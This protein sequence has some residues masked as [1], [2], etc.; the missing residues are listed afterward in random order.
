MKKIFL[1]ILISFS[2]FSQV[3]ELDSTFKFEPVTKRY[4]VFTPLVIQFPNDL[5]LLNFDGN[6]LNNELKE[7]GNF[8]IN[9]KGKIVE[10]FKNKDGL[11][12]DYRQE[13]NL[14][15]PDN[16][17][18]VPNYS[19]YPSFKLVRLFQNGSVDSTFKST[20]SKDYIYKVFLLHN[21]N[22]LV[23]FAAENTNY[24]HIFDKNG[25]FI[26]ILDLTKYGFMPD[27]RLTNL[28]FNDFNE[29]FLLVSDS[30]GSGEIIKTNQDF[31]IDKDFPKIKYKH[32]D[33]PTN[34]LERDKNGFFLLK[35]EDKNKIE[36]YDRNGVK[37]WESKFDD[38]SMYG[39]SVPYVYHQND[40]S[41]DLIYYDRKHIKIKA[42]GAI[43]SVF[44]NNPKQQ[45]IS[46]IHVFADG[47]YWIMQ[48]NSG[49]V[50]KMYADGSIDT[51]FKITLQSE[52]KLLPN[53]IEKLPNKNYLIDLIDYPYN[54][55]SALRYSQNPNCVRIYNGKHQLI[56]DFF[57]SKTIWKTYK[58][59]DSFIVRGD[60]KFYTIDNN[61][62]MSISKDTLLVDDVI[63]WNNN[64]V[65]RKVSENSIVRFKL[66]VGIDKDFSI[67][68]N[69]RIVSFKILNDTQIA[70]QIY[71]NDNFSLYMYYTNGLQDNPFKSIELD[72][73]NSAAPWSQQL[74][75][76]NANG[77]IINQI[78]YIGYG[79]IS[80]RFV[81]LND[82]GSID[83]NYQQNTISGGQYIRYLE[84]GTIYTS[85]ASIIEPKYEQN[86]YNF[87]KILPN[88]KIDSTFQLA[89][90]NEVYGF[91]FFDENTLYATSGKSLYRFIKN[92]LK[93]AEYFNYQTLPTKI[94][95]DY[96]F[97]L[98]IVIK[99]T[100][101]NIKVNVSGN[102]I[103]K[104]SLIAVMPKA[105]FIYV[106][107]TDE[108]NK[109]LAFQ[110]IEV[111]K[112]LPYFIYE[113]RQLTVTSRAFTFKVKASSGL[114][115]K[116]KA[117]GN[118]YAD[119]LIID[120][121]KDQYLSIKLSSNGNEQYES[122]EKSFYW[123]ISSPLANEAEEQTGQ[124]IYY[125]NPVSDKLTIETNNLKIDSFKLIAIDG[126]EIPFSITEEENKYQ[127]TI[128]NLPHG[129]YILL[130]KSKDKQF[131]YR[132]LIE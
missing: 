38:V 73:K 76:D 56:Y 35:T 59:K 2:A 103:L 92:P 52:K 82:D 65:Y 42:D 5:L 19:S 51:N 29:Y 54:Y 23:F 115:V 50:E 15:T 97:P 90:V 91:E 71:N 49:I 12:F 86:V 89:G 24:Y 64:F 104:D 85:S 7:T 120:P 28:V 88:G 126:K 129:L 6:V 13:N 43:D 8:L 58:T 61:S 94:T 110:T 37:I 77:L 118:E 122:I 25:S 124:I 75:L 9:T 31:E 36:K 98:K 46:F 66:G 17:L 114:P 81:K 128:S 108:N 57:D 132:L 40:G 62:K 100:I 4:N 67:Y 11:G 14:I 53:Q 116:I 44:Y 123:T 18:L 60:G 125:P 72:N 16:K 34:K 83:K 21:E 87:L 10:T 130:A 111:T 127:L 112:I 63:D 131:S 113:E 105:G 39:S 20:V 30:N 74:N 119:S 84:D 109:V 107:I 78:L 1:L 22:F 33:S 79:S 106:N 95:W 68:A 99:T 101:K 117:Y 70:V 47:T 96:T 69:R 102:G 32:E 93:K 41:L 55:L 27:A 3:F 26:K 121:K 48:N 80:Q 45:N